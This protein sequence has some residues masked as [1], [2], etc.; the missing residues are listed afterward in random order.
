MTPVAVAGNRAVG[1]RRRTSVH[2]PRAV[3]GTA[4]RSALVAAVLVL[5]TPATAAAA[6]GSPVTVEAAVGA[7]GYVR[8]DAGFTLSVDLTAT[9]LVTGLLRVQLGNEV[10]VEEIELPAGTMKRYLLDLPAPNNQRRLVIDVVEPGADEPLTT[11]RIPLA[12]AT[13]A[14][15]VGVAGDD[16]LSSTID[17]LTSSPY[18]QDLVPVAVASGVDLAP[19]D[20]LVLADAGCCAVE[21]V[22]DWVSAGG[23]LVAPPHVVDAVGLAVGTTTPL[24]GTDASV[25]AVGSGQV[26]IW[27]VAPEADGW[28][29]VLRS[30]PPASTGNA[31]GGGFVDSFQL[32][33][34][35]AASGSRASL[36]LPWLLAALAG[37]V[38]VAGPVNVL[39]LR[40]FGRMEWM[41]ITVPAIGLVTVA[42][43]LLVGRQQTASLH[44]SQASVIVESG[45]RVVAESGIVYFAANEG[46]HTLGFGPDVSARATTDA[47]FAQGTSATVSR[48]DDGG[49]ELAFEL[50]SLGAATAL[51][52]WHPTPSGIDLS[53]RSSDGSIEVSVTNGGTASYWAWGVVAGQRVVVEGDPLEPGETATLTLRPGGRMRDPWASPV[54]DAVMSTLDGSEESW[55]RVYPLAWSGGQL[56]AAEL[57]DALWFY[58]FTD[59]RTVPVATGQGRVDARG[60]AMVVV[61]SGVAGAAADAEIT[62]ELVGTDGQ[63]ESQTGGPQWVFGA[64]YANLR[65]DAREGAAALELGFDNFGSPNLATTMEAWNWESGEFDEVEIGDLLDPASYRSAAGEVMVRLGFE[66][67]AEALISSYWLRG[68]AA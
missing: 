68:E 62:A 22:A 66:Q 36:D 33:E 28:R 61:D 21:D 53:T 41:W 47:W 13:D 12:V 49:T 2:S 55:S 7:A 57:G 16:R 54:A 17:A 50:P 56:A 63:L 20:Y 51:A 30:I 58:G 19:L 40:R 18:N 52:T 10:F 60:V 46:R 64:S 9:R 5:M 38:V 42:G 31:M 6:D 8:P 26:V 45:D 44:V 39:A 24:T 35:A 37:Y 59:D 34:A 48:N 25:A 29:T 4:F 11:E 43:F 14:V 1:E 67:R 27:D 23:R 3:C 15:L 32:F 65:F